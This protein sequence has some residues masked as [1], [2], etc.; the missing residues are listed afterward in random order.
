MVVI[1]DMSRN[2]LLVK[3]KQ[4]EQTAESSLEGAEKERSET[5]RNAETKGHSVIADA[6]NKAEAKA[7]KDLDKAKKD[8]SK[9]KDKFLKEGMT[10]IKKMQSQASKKSEKTA[11]NFVKTFLESVDA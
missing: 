11:D 6:R 7:S 1:L 2:D 10:N 9:K 8:I 4:A 3:I 5:L